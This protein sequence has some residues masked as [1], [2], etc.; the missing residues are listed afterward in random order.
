MLADV[1]DIKPTAN[2][3]DKAKLIRGEGIYPYVTRSELNNGVNDFVC[4]QEGYE[5][6]RGNCITVGLDTQ[7]VFYQ[8][9]DFY[10]GQ[11]IQILRC[12]ELNAYNGKFLLPPL[13]KTLSIFSWGG[14]G[15]TLKRLKRS[16]I[17][18]PADDYDEP[19]WSFMEEYICEREQ[20]LRN[21]HIEYAKSKL[22]T[23]GGGEAKLLNLDGVRWKAFLI[24]DVFV[25]TPGKRL[26]KEDMTE[27]Y[28]PFIGA[29]DSN[30]G[31][32]AF[33][34]N[35]NASEDSNVLGVNYDGSIA[36]SFYHPYTCLFSDSVKRFKIK[37]REGNKYIYE[38][39][40][41]MI[42]Q[43][44]VKYTYGYKFNEQRMK[45]QM[46]MLPIN[47]EGNPD[48]EFMTHYMQA[49]EERLYLR[50]LESKASPFNTDSEQ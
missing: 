32:T 25:I 4:F 41:T 14:Y 23:W 8:P 27:G 29:S 15:A 12:E 5:L 16:K 9:V 48:W 46:I 44:K 42:R 28:K 43:Q 20:K 11:N 3:I 38:F 17:F 39:V 19:D 49:I 30:N 21:N 13:K 31:V 18:L 7:T 50:Y 47:D 40:K 10:T 24:G 37:G 6:N 1:F 36:E 22:R 45:R 33:V 26:R 34:S 2:G 35:S